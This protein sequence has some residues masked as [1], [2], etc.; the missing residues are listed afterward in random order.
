MANQ[1][2]SREVVKMLEIGRSVF[3]YFSSLAGFPKK[4]PSV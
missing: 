1:A 4:V 2:E 3:L